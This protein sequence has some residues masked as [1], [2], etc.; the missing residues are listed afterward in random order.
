MEN[1]LLNRL[2]NCETIKELEVLF[3]PEP[4]VYQKLKIIEVYLSSSTNEEFIH[5]YKI[6][7][8]NEFLN[9]K[10]LKLSRAQSI[11][12]SFLTGSQKSGY[13]QP[14]GKQLFLKTFLENYPSPR[15]L[16]FG[17]EKWTVH[18]L[19]EYLEH[20]YFCTIT[21][22]S[23]RKSLKNLEK[24]LYDKA[25][26]INLEYQNFLFNKICDKNT[27]PYIYFYQLYYSP[28]LLRRKKNPVLHY[29]RKNTFVGCIYGRCRNNGNIIYTR[30]PYFQYT[31][32]DQSNIINLDY[33]LSIPYH[34]GLILLAD[35]PHSRTMVKDF[36][37]WYFIQDKT[38][39]QYNLF[40]IPEEEYCSLSTLNIFNDCLIMKKPMLEFGI[41]YFEK[42]EDVTL[43][44]KFYNYSI[45]S[46]K[47]KKTDKI[48]NSSEES[49]KPTFVL[50]K[51]Y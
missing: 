14:I 23:I 34:P 12:C 32:N 28:Y 35:T 20:K 45:K 37:Y 4:K 1:K 36:Y 9:C 50:K 30:K 24:Y 5:N 51:I 8:P 46:R 2:T 15:F 19:A 25:S 38:P 47:S 33:Y 18:S 3:K 48:S 29:G 42:I 41:K 7:Q 11:I 31:Y 13:I 21:S 40:F 17:E 49:K 27:Y 43:G 39:P 22:D 16:H 26:T 44:R 6:L 10:K